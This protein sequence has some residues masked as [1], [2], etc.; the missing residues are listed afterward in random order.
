MRKRLLLAIMVLLSLNSCAATIHNIPL[1]SPY[2]GNIGAHCADFL[3]SDTQD[4]T[5]AQ[6][7]ALQKQWIVTQCTS[8]TAALQIKAEI[9]QLCSLTA[10]TYEQSAQLKKIVASLDRTLKENRRA[11][12][13]E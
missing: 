5:E 11:M 1:C 13:I 8:D 3:T 2:P 10:C 7:I 6:W 4:L 9:E 12:G